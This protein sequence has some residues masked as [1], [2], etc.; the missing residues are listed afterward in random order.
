MPPR[1]V[2]CYRYGALLH[3]IHPVLQQS[4][5]TRALTVPVLSP[6]HGPGYDM[7]CSWPSFRQK[8]AARPDAA[9]VSPAKE[10][11]T[12][13]L[14]STSAADAIFVSFLLGQSRHLNSLEPIGRGVKACIHFRYAQLF[15]KAVRLATYSGTQMY[16]RACQ[17][18]ENIPRQAP[19]HARD[20]AVI[21]STRTVRV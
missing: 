8:W 2:H 18:K 17:T 1:A 9:V 10:A 6:S 13:Q 19:L 20:S 11:K 7:A 12:A 14:T 21:A 5:G 15:Y 4:T 3:Q 16:C